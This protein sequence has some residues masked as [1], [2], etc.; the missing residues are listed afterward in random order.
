MET[1]APG[2]MPH[3]GPYN[4]KGVA[5][6]FVVNDAGAIAWQIEPFNKF[7]STSLK[8]GDFPLWNPYAG[9]AGSPLLA[10]G[11]TGPLEPIQFLFFLF[12][13]RLWPL[14]IDLQ[15]LIRFLIAGFTCYLFARRQGINFLGSIAAGILFMLS[16]YFVTFGNHPQVKTEALLPLVLYGYDRLVN[17][18][19][20]LGFWLCTLFVG[21]AIIAA[22]PESTFFALFLGTLWY[23]Y[24]SLLQW[25]TDD[26]SFQS[27]KNLLLRYLSSTLFGF[28]ISAAYLLPFLEFVWFGRS[29]HSSG[30][31]RSPYA[32]RLLPGLIFQIQPKFF[33]QLGFFS[34]FSMVFSLLNYKEWFE[35]RKTIIFFSAY[36][37]FFILLIFQLPL[38]DWIRN[39][40]I[41]NQLVLQKYSVPSIVFCLANLVGIL[42]EGVTNSY[43][44]YKKLSL[45]FLILGVV[46]ILVP[47]VRSLDS[48]S[49]YSS[50]LQ[51]VSFAFGL[52]ISIVVLL[53]L[54][55]IYQRSRLFS[56]HIVQACLLMIVVLE[57]FF[58]ET[59]INRPNRVDPFQIPPFVSFLNKKENFRVFGLDGTLYPNISTAYRIE[60]IRWLDAVL[61]QR[62]YDFSA[63]YI[64]SSEVNS[65]RLSGTILP[66]SD[67][68][69]SLLNVKYVLKQNS[70]IKNS[71]NCSFTTDSQPYFGAETLNPLIFE[72]NQDKKNLSPQRPVNINGATHLSLFVQPPQKLNVNLLIPNQTP[73]LT[74]S[75]GLNPKVFRPEYGDGVLF[76][77]MLIKQKSKV[78]IFS[79]YI[80]PKNNP[81]DR[82]WFDESI[83]LKKWAGQEV[84]LRFITTGGPTG[85]IFYDW[86]YWGDIRFAT[87]SNSSNVQEVRT[88]SPYNLVYQDQEVLIYQNEDVLP[89]A[90][91]MYSLTNISNFGDALVQLTNPNID[92]RKTAVVENLPAELENIINEKDQPIKLAEAHT[93]LVRSGELDVKVTTPSPGLLVVKDQYYPG[94]KA[95]VNGKPTPIYAVDGI[96]RGIFLD[97]GE[98]TV[99]FKYR[100]LSF[101]IGGIIS[102]IS[103]VTSIF[104]LLFYS[105][106]LQN[107]HD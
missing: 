84:A 26:H 13:D 88:D 80:D 58:W 30:M 61:P 76:K 8:K 68:W 82:K 12:P 93:R 65:M 57:P 69:F 11:H 10:D 70:S 41:F 79:K 107:H 16:S 35:R 78:E 23:C 1:A 43:I 27:A 105:Y 83:D 104:F 54:L 17:P 4:Y 74:F 95:Y 3:A 42:I 34:V 89:R 14:A 64:E 25:Q 33:L 24:R 22:M 6:G 96:F 29:I 53:Y 49:D 63:K 19:D 72:K 48:I 71:D 46:F 91:M 99:E 103:L 92:I 77:V 81:C 86:A 47:R 75:I 31:A 106:A 94:W 36:A 28:L 50:D 7:I 37:I 15:L 40:P 9:L 55:A 52:I 38:T 21:W 44:S 5:P 20:K 67:K 60:D 98:H 102:S 2:T 100:P 87:T 32:L 45:S 73:K 90:L 85:N 66:I 56:Q 97:A 59:R 18:K 101:I 39:L 62:A 51:F